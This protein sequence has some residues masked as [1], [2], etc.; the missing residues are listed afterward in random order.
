MS[1]RYLTGAELGRLIGI[2]RQAVAEAKRKGAIHTNAKGLFD[3]LDLDIEEWL[4]KLPFQRTAAAHKKDREAINPS[5]A[6]VLERATKNPPVTAG[7]RTIVDAAKAAAREDAELEE[8]KA[9]ARYRSSHGSTRGD[10]S[11]ADSERKLKAAQA[12]FWETRAKER[13]GEYIPRHV[14]ELF[15]QKLWSI[16]SSQFLTRGDR[17]ADQLAAMARSAESDSK[18]SLQINDALTRDAYQEQGAK[19]RDMTDFLKQIKSKHS[20]DDDPDAA[21]FDNDDD[22]LGDIDDEEASK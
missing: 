5:A 8:R 6:S 4:K 10:P 14:V 21:L 16:D 1:E 20:I 19:K 2:S 11:Y 9:S 17:I 15:I 22:E 18:A 12:D 13:R 7:A 3:L